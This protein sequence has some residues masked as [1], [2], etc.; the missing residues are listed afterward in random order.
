M[1]R[2]GDTFE[3][4]GRKFRVRMPYDDDATAPWKREDGH[5]V[6]S[7]WTSRAKRPGEMVLCSDRRRVKRYYDFAAAVKTARKDG[8][9]AEPYSDAETAGQRAHKAAMADFRYLR[10][11]AN[12]EWHY[13]G[14]IVEL[15]DDEGDTI[16]GEDASL[17][18]VE[19]Y[20]RAYLGKVAAELADEVLYNLERRIALRA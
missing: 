9:D 19:G 15:L 18:G 16:E 10:G 14:V 7:E 20:A 6:V 2:D 17:W 5:G 8:W 11:W 1:L 4:A 13:V 12:D 3:R